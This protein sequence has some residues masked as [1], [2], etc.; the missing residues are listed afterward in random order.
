MSIPSVG[1]E[2]QPLVKSSMLYQTGVPPFCFWY[3]VRMFSRVILNCTHGTHALFL[4]SFLW[5]V[6]THGFHMCIYSKQISGDYVQ[7]NNIFLSNLTALM[8]LKKYI[9]LDNKFRLFNLNSID[10]WHS[11]VFVMLSCIDLYNH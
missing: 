6:L 1:L 2:L 5:Y 4:P 10:E 3:L 11:V 9:G 7:K 8:Q